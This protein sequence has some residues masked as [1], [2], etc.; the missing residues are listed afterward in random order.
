MIEAD[1]TGFDAHGIVRLGHYVQLAQVRPGQGQ[2]Q[3]QG[4][5]ALALDR[6]GR[7]RRRHR[8]SGDDLCDESRHRTGA[9]D[10]HR[11]G[12]RA[13]FQSRRRRRHLSGDGG[14]ARHDRHLR[15]GV[16]DEPHGAVG[17]RR[18]ADGHQPDRHRD[19][20][21]QGSAG[22]ARHR[23]LGVL[24]RQHPAAPGQRRAAAGGLG[25]AQQD[26]R[27][28]HSIRRRSTRAC[29]C[30]SAATRAAGWR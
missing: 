15:R 8:P 9:E 23:H 20:G 2:G 21:R 13:Q 11:L 26:R 4:A 1:L 7:W 22:G 30:R 19:S 10:R 28:D 17:R 29:C 12:R 18:A 25:G 6:A 24:V 5:A 3:H 27:A 14:G 16:D